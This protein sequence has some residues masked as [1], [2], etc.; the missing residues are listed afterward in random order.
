MGLN[1]LPYKNLNSL[2]T[3]NLSKKE[4]PETEIIIKDLSSVKRRGYLTK[5]ELKTIC[6][7]KSSRA[8]WLI[9]QNSPRSIKSISEKALSSKS[10]RTKIELLTKL[11]GVSIPMA[12]AILMLL[13]PKRYGVIDIRVWQLL[14]TMK[15]VTKKSSGVGF[16]FN[17]WYHYLMIIRYYAKKYDVKVRDIERTLFNVHALYQKDSLYKG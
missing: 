2:I 13:N 12:S 8:I 11:Q 10:E 3:A 9:E 15:S 14:Y 1:K 4:H 5:E 7:W 6:R 16:S 17:N